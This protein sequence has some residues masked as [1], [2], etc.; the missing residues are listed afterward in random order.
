MVYKKP[1]L[2][3][4]Q[5][6]GW[7]LIYRLN[8]LFGKV[9]KFAPSGRY[10]DWNFT[11]D[12]IW[13]NL[14]YRNDIEVEEDGEGKIISVELSEQDT[15]I[16]FFLDKKIMIAKSNV[17]RVSDGDSKTFNGKKLA[18]AK[19]EYYNSLML[20]DIWLR[21]FMSQLGLYLKEVEH[22]PS[23]AIYGR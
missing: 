8:D 4:Q 17:N 13:C 14:L 5:D 12:R 18:E 11:L 7:G 21:K 15:R 3:P 10:D 16:K 6:T 1:S 20:K 19:L 23:K 2:V 22:D 9:E